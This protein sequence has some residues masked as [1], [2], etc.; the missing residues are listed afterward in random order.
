MLWGLQYLFRP[1]RAKLIICAADSE[2][3]F[4]DSSPHPLNRSASFPRLSLQLS[5]VLH[6]FQTI[7]NADG[8]FYTVTCVLLFDTFSH[9]R[10]AFFSFLPFSIVLFLYPIFTCTSSIVLNFILLR[11]S[12]NATISLSVL[13]FIRL[14][15]PATSGFFHLMYLLTSLPPLSSCYHVYFFHVRMVSS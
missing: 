10:I 1:A 8:R 6:S 4:L 11:A 13:I 9:L 5:I 12:L 3:T 7:L 14:N 15:P 2:V